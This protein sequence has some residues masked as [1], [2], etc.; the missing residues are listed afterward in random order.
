MEASQSSLLRAV[1]IGM[2]AVCP[3]PALK[4]RPAHFAG[5]ARARADRARHAH[6]DIL[7]VAPPLVM[8]EGEIDEM[9]EMTRAALRKVTDKLVAAGHALA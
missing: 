3:G 7:G 8:N 9:V 2:K 5:R 1:T 4:V 6:G